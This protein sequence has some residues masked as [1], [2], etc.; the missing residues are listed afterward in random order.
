MFGLRFDAAP[1][2]SQVGGEPT[3]G[4]PAVVSIDASATAQGHCDV[5]DTNFPSGV[6]VWQPMQNTCSGVSGWRLAG[7][8]ACA[9]TCCCTCVVV[10]AVVVPSSPTVKPWS[11]V[12]LVSVANVAVVQ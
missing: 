12:L 8:G 6:A 4:A 3:A 9:R 11:V 7:G 5:K 2:V 10:S 1:L